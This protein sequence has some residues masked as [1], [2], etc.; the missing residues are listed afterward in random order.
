ME[1]V[2]LVFDRMKQA[3]NVNVENKK[4]YRIQ[5]MLAIINT[6]T[7]TAFFGI[8]YSYYLRFESSGFNLAILKFTDLVPILTTM[9][10]VFIVFLL[11]LIIFEAGLFHMYYKAVY[12]G[13][14]NN[15]DFAEGVRK[16]FS[17][18]FWVSFL[19]SIFWIILIPVYLIA[20]LFTFG[21]GFLIIPIIITTFLSMWKVSL[22]VDECGIF[23]ALR[24]S[25]SFAGRN[26]V[27]YIFFILLMLA[28]TAP[29][30]QNNFGNII[31]FVQDLTEKNKQ[32]QDNN[33]LP[34]ILDK[35]IRE[36]KDTD[37][38]EEADNQPDL[39]VEKSLSDILK[40]N[41]I[42]D[43]IRTSDNSIKMD[44]VTKLMGEVEA[45]KLP[46]LFGED[47][48]NNVSRVLKEASGAIKMILI[49]LILVIAVGTFISSFIKMFF[50]IFF[51]LA[52]FVIYKKGF[53]KEVVESGEVMQS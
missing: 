18:F 7:T 28:F 38:L 24:N 23:S 6:I 22:V 17:K 43:E 42:G 40:G 45:D 33:E 37:Y 8:L 30:K 51:M 4:I 50:Q 14:V 53:A 3:F 1:K 48:M 46:K 39:N 44:D 26:F 16:Y 13:T 2:L 35:S 31:S 29:V 27:P 47:F 21:A 36:L 34:N 9:F 15:I 52:M 41:K 10:F 20:G 12:F 25:F 19:T 11:V 32:K 5:I 49:T